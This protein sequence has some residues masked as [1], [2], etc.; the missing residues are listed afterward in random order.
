[1]RAEFDLVMKDADRIVSN[2]L[3]PV[4]ARNSIS[5]L[6]L[7]LSVMVDRIEAVEQTLIRT[8]ELLKN[9]EEQLQCQTPR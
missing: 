3:V 4:A 1:M 8:G 7:L 5:S 9:L 2:V 6:Q